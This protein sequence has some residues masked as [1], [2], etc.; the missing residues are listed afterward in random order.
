MVPFD[1]EKAATSLAGSLSKMLNGSVTDGIR[2]TAAVSQAD[3]GVPNRM[4]V[5][6]G[7]TSKDQDLRKGI[8][9]SVS[10]QASLYLGY[11]MHLCSDDAAKYMMTT[12]SIVLLCRDQELTQELLHYDYERNKSDGYTEAH[13]QMCATSEHWDAVLA[14]TG[15]KQRPLHKLHLPVGGRRF[16]PA[17][18]DIIEFLIVEKLVDARPKW[19]E[20]LDASRDEFQDIQL[21]AAVRRKADVAADV[22][23]RAG[24]V[25]TPPS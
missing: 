3:R 12:D 20:A 19:K 21:R 2:I 23:R 22:L 1:L 16:R 15:G 13:L 6:Y 25:V 9:L 24:W 8:P 5:G 14:Q 17:L 18:E 4:N 11:F 10:G 7:V